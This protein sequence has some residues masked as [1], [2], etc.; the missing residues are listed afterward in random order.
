MPSTARPTSVKTRPRCPWSIEER[1]EWLRLL[2]ESGQTISEFCR[3]ND[4]PESTLSLW[5]RQQ[6]EVRSENDGEFVEVA[7]PTSAQTASPVPATT[8]SPAVVIQLPGDR[9]V[10]VA[11]GTGI[12]WLS[13]LLRAL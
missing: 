12:A 2:D 3:A 6:R 11:A 5:R 1:V 13:A 9:I 7:L 8:P 10:E 4:L